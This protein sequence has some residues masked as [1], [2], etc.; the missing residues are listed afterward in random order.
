MAGMSVELI[1][2]DADDDYF[3]GVCAQ[4]VCVTRTA[5]PEWCSQM[6]ATGALTVRL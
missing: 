6:D 5:L 1:L 4:V 3:H 2:D